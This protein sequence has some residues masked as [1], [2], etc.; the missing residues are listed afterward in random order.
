[1]VKK[2]E[3]NTVRKRYGSSGTVCVDVWCVKLRMAVHEYAW[4]E[5]DAVEKQGG[6][7]E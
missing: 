7:R 4:F 6:K 2:R 5:V 1:M 3:V